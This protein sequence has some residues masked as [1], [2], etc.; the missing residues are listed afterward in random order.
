MA[1]SV[2]NKQ[3]SVSLN[4][5]LIIIFDCCLDIASPFKDTKNTSVECTFA[6]N[7]VC[8]FLCVSYYGDSK[9]TNH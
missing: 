2:L 1:F 9:M 5:I 7:L 4:T 6:F 3:L 8:I